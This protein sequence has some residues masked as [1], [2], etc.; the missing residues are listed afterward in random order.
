M[1]VT[2]MTSAHTRND[3]RIFL[4][5]C[6]SL[7]KKYT[8]NLIVADGKGDEKRSNVNIIDAGSSKNRAIR[9]FV[10][11]FSILRKAIK[12]KSRVFHFHDPELILIGLILKG[13][14][15]KVIYDAHENLAATVSYKEYLPV[16]LRPI[17]A[18]S[19][20]LVEKISTLFFDGV[21]TVNKS[22]SNL[23]QDKKTYIVPNYV[24]DGEFSS[25]LKIEKENHNTFCYVG[26]LSYDRGIYHLVEAIKDLDVNLILAGPFSSDDFREKVMSLPGWK[27]VDYRG[28][29]SRQEISR[30]YESVVVGML[31]LLPHPNYI[32][33]SPTKLYEYLSAGLP[34]I[35]SN[36]DTFRQVIEA[37][38]CGLLVDPQSVDSIKE[39]LMKIVHNPALVRG[40]A[41]SAKIA[42]KK[43]TWKECETTLFACYEQI[44]GIQE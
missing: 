2:H 36:F 13:L 4:K 37:T 11:P 28:V 41:A 27:K 18:Q 3:P 5:E 26:G 38:N 23:F 25:T 35:S 39:A 15:K 24:I 17:I 7:A 14:G 22:I 10:K 43:Y 1:I 16:Y 34:V 6:R 32:D 31:T 30:I 40:M 44:I 29:V 33:S 12:S 8:V 19:V 20:R 9:I 21:V 42:S